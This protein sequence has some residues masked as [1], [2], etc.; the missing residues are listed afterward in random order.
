MHASPN[1]RL[2][3]LIFKEV[4]QR[5]SFQQ[6]IPVKLSEALSLKVEVLHRRKI[7]DLQLFMSKKRRKMLKIL[8]MEEQLLNCLKLIVNLCRTNNQILIGQVMQSFSEID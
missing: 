7:R 6:A 8:Q 5:A 1:K 3:L 4:H 2:G